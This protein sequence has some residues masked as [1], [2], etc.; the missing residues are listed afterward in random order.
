M[1]KVDA[2]TAADREGHDRWGNTDVEPGV[3]MLED[4][5]PALAAAPVANCQPGRAAAT[6]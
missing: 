6:P 5:D 1:R 3:I 4:K 2:P